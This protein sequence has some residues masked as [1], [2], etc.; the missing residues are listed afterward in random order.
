[1]EDQAEPRLGGLVV[2]YHPPESFKT[3]LLSYLEGLDACMVLDN[4]PLSQKGMLQDL[5]KDYPIE[6]RHFPENL[7]VARA[8]NQGAEWGLSE[9]FD[10]LLTMDQDSAFPWGT[11]ARIRDLLPSGPN[12]PWGILAPVI[13][14]LEDDPRYRQE[15]NTLREVPWLITSGNFLNLEAYKVCGAFQDELFIDH[16]DHEYCLRLRKAGY[17]LGILPEGKLLHHLGEYKQIRWGKK[18]L[19][20]FTSHSPLRRYYMVRNGLWV[21]RKYRQD[22]P[23][24]YRLN[25]RLIAQ[26]LF[27]V[28]FLEKNKWEQLRMIRWAYRDYLQNQLG[29]YPV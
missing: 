26:E 3:N 23:E 9:G 17:K 2:L 16:I 21:A 24:F 4:S 15:K 13:D 14:S 25:R 19:L 8:L 28:L 29:K 27:K 1:M 22:F 20:R 6:Y 10:Y 5:I 12:C 7:G 18:T 11:F